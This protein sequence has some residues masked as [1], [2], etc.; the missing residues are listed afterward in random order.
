MSARDDGISPPV[1]RAHH[2]R[3]SCLIDE[4]KGD[5]NANFAALAMDISY[6]IQTCLEL[7][8]SSNLDR[9]H[10]SDT[11]PGNVVL[12]TL[13]VAD[14]CRLLRL[15]IASAG[16]LGGAAEDRVDRLSSLAANKKDAA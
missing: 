5:E 8:E 7:V 10:N 4:L 9:D 2:E 12:P 14:T 6:G 1:R 3:F 11:D 15:A 13:D 16:L